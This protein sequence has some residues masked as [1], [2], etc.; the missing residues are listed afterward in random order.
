[1]LNSLGDDKG[2]LSG[3]KQHSAPV[4]GIHK[5]NPSYGSSAAAGGLGM[6][7]ELSRISMTSQGA[8]NRNFMQD[9]IE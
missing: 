4:E 5:V 6:N 7:H 9:Q 2:A 3:H 1:M 8:N